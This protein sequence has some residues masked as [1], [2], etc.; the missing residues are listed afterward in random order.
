VLTPFWLVSA[1]VL[2]GAIV[3]RRAQR[4]R[5]RSGEASGEWTPR[6]GIVLVCVASAAMTF[7]FGPW[8]YSEVIAAWV[9][10]DTSLTDTRFLLFPALLAGALLGGWTR[11]RLQPRRPTFPVVWR[12]L[13]G[14]ALMA[15]GARMVPGANDGLLLMGLPKL[16]P[17][18]LVG[19]G[20]MILTLVILM[21][22]ARRLRRVSTEGARQKG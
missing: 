14:G 4:V 21:V 17:E 3:W 11:G 15:I 16:A 2:G 6:T 9:R 12:C 19:L 5:A 7:A 18:A 8:V 22:G 20:S 1:A 10:G 13:L